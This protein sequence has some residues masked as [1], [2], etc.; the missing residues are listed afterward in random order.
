MVRNFRIVKSAPCSPTRVCRKSTGPPS[1]ILMVRATTAISGRV[2]TTTSAAMVTSETRFTLRRQSDGDGTERTGGGARRR[3]GCAPL[4]DGD[5]GSSDF[6]GPAGSISTHTWRLT[7]RTFAEVWFRS[8]RREDL[9]RLRTRRPGPDAKHLG[10]LNICPGLGPGA[11]A[12]PDP[13]GHLV[14][15]PRPGV[16]SSEVRVPAAGAREPGL[17]R[18][19]SE[20]LVVYDGRRLLH[21]VDPAHDGASWAPLPD[22]PR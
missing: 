16:I 7:V 21:S 6:P 8:A 11:V 20:S 19:V 1:T 13:E 3:I 18:A 2:M 12:G 14:L 9:P 22:R 4:L 5:A 10:F 17:I 15:M